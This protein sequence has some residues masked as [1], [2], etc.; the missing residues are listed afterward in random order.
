MTH[1]LDVELGLALLAQLAHPRDEL[2]ERVGEEKREWVG[3]EVVVL[4]EQQQ[5][6][7]QQQRGGRE[8]GKV[9]LLV[10]EQQQQ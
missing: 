10:V 4:V 1:G 8:E 9:Q 3:F 2:V 7:Q 5:Q 6:Q